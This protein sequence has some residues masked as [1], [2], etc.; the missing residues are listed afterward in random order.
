MGREEDRFAGLFVFVILSVLLALAYNLDTA[1]SGLTT[2]H[3][4]QSIVHPGY[5][6]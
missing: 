4:S 2:P 1:H 6:F 5:S 3:V